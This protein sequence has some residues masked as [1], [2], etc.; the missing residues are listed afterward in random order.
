MPTVESPPVPPEARESDPH[1]Y[2]WRVV[3][4]ANLGIMVGFSIYA[5]TFSIFVKPLASQFGWSRQ[6]ISQGFALSALACAILSPWPDAG[7]TATLS[8][9]CYSPA[10]RSLD[11]PQPR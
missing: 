5:H 1:Y 4:A 9:G 2:G 7:L 3:F 10:W 11:S 8:G 6:A